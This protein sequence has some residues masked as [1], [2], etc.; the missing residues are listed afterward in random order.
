M[1][2]Q[3]TLND[4]LKK[5]LGSSNCNELGDDVVNILKQWEDETQYE[6]NEKALVTLDP[7]VEEEQKSL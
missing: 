2:K 4:F 7:P 1:E 5:V 6:N 3:E